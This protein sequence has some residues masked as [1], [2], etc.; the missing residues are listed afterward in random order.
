MCASSLELLQPQLQGGQPPDPGKLMLGK[1]T[2]MSLHFL[3]LASQVTV[4]G[5]HAL[6]VGI[7]CA[8][9]EE[10]GPLGKHLLSCAGKGDRLAC[11]GV[12]ACMMETL[13][14]LH[15]SLIRCA[16]PELYCGQADFASW[17]GG[18]GWGV[19]RSGLYNPDFNLAGVWAAWWLP[20]EGV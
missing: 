16:G 18:W 2:C 19:T 7:Y 4:L 5:V 20:H 14:S 15:P 17:P 12:C 9:D 10:I 1:E 3:A 13:A 11:C 6:I 8:G